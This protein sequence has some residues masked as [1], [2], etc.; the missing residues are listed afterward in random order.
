MEHLEKRRILNALR[1]AN[2]YGFRIHSVK[3]LNFN[4]L[5]I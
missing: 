5:A 3:S 1:I 4:R 2:L